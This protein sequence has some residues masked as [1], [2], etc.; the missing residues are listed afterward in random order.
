MID[1]GLALER[2]AIDRPAVVDFAALAALGATLERV[3]KVITGTDR[4]V[5]QSS[6]G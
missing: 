2:A 5:D 4:T 6:S 3:E 1:G